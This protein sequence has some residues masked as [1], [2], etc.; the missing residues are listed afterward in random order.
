MK[1]LD[2]HPLSSNHD[3]H[4]FEPPVPRSLG[5]LSKVAFFDIPHDREVSTL[6]HDVA[7]LQSA[8]TYHLTFFENRKYLG[9]LKQTQAGACLVREEDRP[10]VPP[11]TIPLIASDPYRSYALV[12]Q[13]LYP[14]L[15][16]REY[17]EG[18]HPTAQIH[19]SASLG[20]GC[21]V[22]AYTVIEE[23]VC[24]GTGTYIGPHGVIGA[25]CQVG[26]HCRIES[27]V[28][29]K[30]SVI[31]HRVRLHAGA[32]VGQSGFGFHMGAQGFTPIPHLGRVIIQDD[33]R[34]GA[35]TTID[36][37][38]LGDTVIGQGTMIDNVVQIGHNVSLGHHCVLAGQVGIAGSAVLE[39]GCVLGGQSGI[40]GHVRIGQG[41]RLGAKGGITNDTAPHSVLAGFP[42]QPLRA[43]K[44]WV[45]L[46][47]QLLKRSKSSSQED[48]TYV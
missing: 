30:Y 22:G 14:S 39:A 32:R 4:F 1:A 47:K 35:N 27:H 42:A 7:P 6:I 13:T 19:P 34:I 46:K 23:R 43:W 33:V 10:H 5:E 29:I 36:R 3:Q 38:S 24:I 11:S 2:A 16:V 9:A 21:R 18:I 48:R 45:A 37:G 8:M 12:A 26:E 28:S 31:G 40:A 20:E 44:R 25:G 15:S 41:T 17:P